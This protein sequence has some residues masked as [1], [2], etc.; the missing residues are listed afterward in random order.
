[1]SGIITARC[2]SAI[3]R[4]ETAQVLFQLPIFLVLTLLGVQRP[5]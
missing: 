5:I 3:G 2:F 4:F 1:M